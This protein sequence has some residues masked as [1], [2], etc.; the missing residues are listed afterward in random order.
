MTTMKMKVRAPFTLYGKKFEKGDVHKFPSQVARD[1]FHEGYLDF[2][3]EK[4]PREPEPTFLTTRFEKI[5]GK[6]ARGEDGKLT[7]DYKRW[8]RKRHQTQSAHEKVDELAAHIRWL[9]N[10]NAH[11]RKVAKPLKK[12]R[13]LGCTFKWKE[14]GGT[15]YLKALLCKN[16]RQ[17]ERSL[18]K[19]S[20][21]FFSARFRA[22]IPA[23][24]RDDKWYTPILGK[25]SARK[26]RLEDRKS[27]V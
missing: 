15:E 9:R 3:F 20:S 7:K 27:V 13:E 14:T 25:K 4:K 2:Y 10:K 8:R 16:N 11:P 21:D 26:A 18:G 5:T 17:T 6:T 24:S 23:T 12:L 22:E 1:L 19:D